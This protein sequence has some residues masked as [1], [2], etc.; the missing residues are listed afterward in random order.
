MNN[1]S[2]TTPQSKMQELETLE[3]T[4][5]HGMEACASAFEALLQIRDKE[6]YKLRGYESFADYCRSELHI[7]KSQAYRLIKHMV[8]CKALNVPSD[9][10][11]EKVTRSLS[12]IK[13][14]EEQR[15]VWEEA[16]TENGGKYPASRVME[17]KVKDHI[18][19]QKA[20]QEQPTPVPEKAA[21]D[22]QIIDVD[23]AVK[24]Y[25]SSDRSISLEEALAFGQGPRLSE[26]EEAQ[27]QE[28][29]KQSLVVDHATG[30]EN[31]IVYKQADNLFR[32][33]DD[34]RETLSHLQIE[35]GM[36]EVKAR[37]IR[38]IETPHDEEENE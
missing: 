29:I 1:A 35:K 12:G 10:V 9:A 25:P 14:K 33:I 22:D 38:Y 36:D 27:L 18:R 8:T 32:L 17:Q 7:G 2:I 4:I 28:L 21:A 13:D 23:Y 26:Q 15:K 6:L 3:K 30:S 24:T 37:L 19:K 5:Q 16:I 31:A 34:K 20:E 11:S